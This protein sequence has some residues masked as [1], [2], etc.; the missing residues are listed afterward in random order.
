MSSAT[1]AQTAICPFDATTRRYV[2][3]RARRP[4]TP[5]LADRNA[6][7][8]GEFSF[9]INTMRPV[10][11]GPHKIDAITPVDEL[12][13][14]LIRQVF[15]GGIANGRFDD[16]KI[17][18]EILKGKRTNQEVRLILQPASRAI[19]LE[20]LKKG[21][22]RVFVEAG[23]IIVNPGSPLFGG[24]M[25]LLAQDEKGLTT[26]FNIDFGSGSG[27]I[28]QVSPATAAASALTGR[29]TNPSAYVKV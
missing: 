2:N 10:A 19:Y 13:G 20:A 26:D 27:Q 17:V 18:A 29:I 12:N 21:L 5:I 25:P 23:A 16:L 11:A 22:I 6:D 9:E 7:Y 1:G 3:P 14:V 15:I 28:Y 4:F 8:A 24:M